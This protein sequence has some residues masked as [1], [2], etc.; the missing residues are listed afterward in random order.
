[1]NWCEVQLFFSALPKA[2]RFLKAVVLPSSNVNFP[3]DRTSD[4]KGMA[5]DNSCTK[6]GSSVS[7]GPTPK[8]Y[9]PQLFL[10]RNSTSCA[11]L[12]SYRSRKLKYAVSARLAKRRNNY[13][14]FNFLQ[15]NLGIFHSN[16]LYDAPLEGSTIFLYCSSLGLTSMESC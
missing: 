4:K 13:S 10:G 16:E 5:F 14:S 9:E 3:E 2:V 11:S 7:P 1:M 8:R 6:V 12:E 15:E